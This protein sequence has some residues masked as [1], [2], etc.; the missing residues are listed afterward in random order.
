MQ[1][2]PLSAY[3]ISDRGDTLF[4]ETINCGCASS[5]GGSSL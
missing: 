3:F 5:H 4:I 1:F 2:R